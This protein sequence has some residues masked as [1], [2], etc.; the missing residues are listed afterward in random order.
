MFD[1]GNG[2]N[3]SLLLEEMIL[4]VAGADWNDDGG[5]T[6]PRIVSDK[7]WWEF[8]NSFRSRNFDKLALSKQVFDFICDLCINNTEEQG[9]CDNA[10]EDGIED[11]D[12]ALATEEVQE[13]HYDDVQA[14]EA[15]HHQEGTKDQEFEEVYQLIKSRRGKM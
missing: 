11:E 12:E 13:E 4:S 14:E 10:V 7:V 1:D 3:V 9:S 2:N 8:S 6:P 15:D 5:P